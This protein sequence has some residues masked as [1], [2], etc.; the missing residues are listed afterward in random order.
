MDVCR[1]RNQ[2]CNKIP[3]TL[4]VTLVGG[5]LI[6]SSSA[7]W[8]EGRSALVQTLLPFAI[9]SALHLRQTALFFLS[10]FDALQET[11]LE[12][13]C[14]LQQVDYHSYISPP[15]SFFRNTI[16]LVISPISSH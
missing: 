13:P 10:G 12:L 6:K 3:T 4:L 1:G 5:F 16:C 2:G 9:C 7:C 11:A 8:K 15:S 14:T